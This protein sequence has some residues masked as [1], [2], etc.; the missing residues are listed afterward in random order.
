MAYLVR[1][2]MENS[3]Q[4]GVLAMMR[5][6]QNSPLIKS[7]LSIFKNLKEKK[8]LSQSS[9]LL[10]SA[11][12][13][14]ISPL[15]LYKKENLLALEKKM[16]TASLL[17]IEIKE[18]ASSDVTLKMETLY[19]SFKD[20]KGWCSFP[21]EKKQFILLKAARLMTEQRLELSSLIV[22]EAHKTRTEALADVDEAIDFIH[23]YAKEMM[24]VDHLVPRGVIGVIAPWNFPL[25]IPCGM[26]VGALACGNHV[27]LKPADQTPKIA[28]L[29]CRLLWSAGV[30][31]ES[32]QLAIGAGA[33]VGSA[34][35]DSERLSG[36]VFTGSKAVGSMLFK[37]LSSKLI[38]HPWTKQWQP[39]KVIV[40][41]GGK[42]AVIVTQNAELDETVSG[43]VYSALAHAGQKCSAASRIL[44][45]NELKDVLISRLK[46]AFKD[47]NVGLATDSSTLINPL[48]SK[49]EA[50]RV[51][52]TIKE[53]Y[54]EASNN[55][56]VVHADFSSSILDEK[57]VGPVLVEYPAGVNEENGK[58]LFHEIFAPIVHVVGYYNLNHAIDLF[59][60]TQYG[61]TGGIFSQSE[62]DIEFL[63][64]NLKAGNLY[65]NRP[66]TGARVGIEPFGGFKMS[67]TGPKA[68]SQQ[69]LR[70]FVFSP[71]QL[72]NL[73]LLEDDEFTDFRLSKKSTLSALDNNDILNIFK[74]LQENVER[75]ILHESTQVKKIISSHLLW[76][77]TS[78]IN[79]L[80]KKHQNTM[81]PGQQSFDDLSLKKKDCL[82]F[83]ESCELD[84]VSFLFLINSLVSGNH[85][86]LICSNQ[87]IFDLLEQFSSVIRKAKPS[88]DEWTLIRG[89]RNLSSMSSQITPELI[90][91]HSSP[92]GVKS[93][94]NNVFDFFPSSLPQ[95][96]SS[97]EYPE[98]N[99]PQDWL[100]LFV[101]RRSLA[102]N[103]MRHGAPLKIEGQE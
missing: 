12:F 93:I 102:I 4:V 83:F 39:V 82:A 60:Q 94:I 98:L 79:F 18:D 21:H 101:H 95:F 5:S 92:E 88:W 27:I 6:H 43:I 8:K 56:G 19:Q 66:N 7:P 80:N 63:L 32:C 100:E 28:T 47:V 35:S 44:V 68:G 1:R 15:R 48:I 46:K 16:N 74:A 64:K 36:L 91:I 2:I 59:N 26:L 77:K 42:N 31:L 87:K 53:I 25:A 62:D 33:V 85:L 78:G 40:E 67:G 9:V 52:Q 61:L 3:S 99:S 86:Y 96:I 29:L 89:K 14:N 22:L 34:I 69:Y 70:S 76:L 24:G 55:K 54:Q 23:F 37:K 45:D 65:I 50:Q 81:I 17:E 71:D 84:R 103:T 49:K 41:M 97:L 13:K 72:K 30:P 10:P 20:K 73:K 57:I 58:W 51:R 38:E 90:F 75:F 11:T